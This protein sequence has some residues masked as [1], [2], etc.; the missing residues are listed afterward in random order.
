MKINKRGI[1]AVNADKEIVVKDWSVDS[2]GGSAND[3]I[4]AILSDVRAILNKEIK[5]WKYAERKRK[6]REAL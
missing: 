6:E 5:R 4:I 3:C 2:E 1:V